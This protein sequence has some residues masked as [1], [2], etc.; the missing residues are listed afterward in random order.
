MF[1]V[2]TSQKT[3]N[4]SNPAGASGASHRVE[5]FAASPHTCRPQFS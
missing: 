2:S 3:P 4:A 5:A 1:I